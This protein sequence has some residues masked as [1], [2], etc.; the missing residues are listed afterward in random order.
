MSAR[1]PAREAVLMEIIRKPYLILHVRKKYFDEIN[2]GVKDHEY[3]RESPYWTRRLSGPPG[4][5]ITYDLVLIACGYPKKKD[6]GKWIAF[7]YNGY[8]YMPI[9]HPEFG[10]EPV[11]VYAVSVHPDQR[12]ELP[13]GWI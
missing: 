9:Q 10:P 13:P 1:V 6:P 12:T 8:H 11:Q 4:Q 7:R 5:G 3:R 2:A